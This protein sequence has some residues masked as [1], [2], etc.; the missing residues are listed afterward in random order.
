MKLSKYRGNLKKE[1][2]SGLTLLP[3]Q[4]AKAS[5]IGYR[6]KS[7]LKGSILEKLF[8]G[9]NCYRKNFSKKSFIIEKTFIGK[10]CYRKNDIDIIIGI[11]FVYLFLIKISLLIEKRFIGNFF[12]CNRKYF[13]RKIDNKK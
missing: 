2:L 6:K 9:K 13:C 11:E 4:N 10:Y 7:L 3:E 8:T 12:F 1:K 5:L